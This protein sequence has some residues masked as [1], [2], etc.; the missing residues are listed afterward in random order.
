[1]VNMMIKPG[2]YRVLLLFVLK[3]EYIVTCIS[4]L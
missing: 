2:P 3:L 4:I 1:M